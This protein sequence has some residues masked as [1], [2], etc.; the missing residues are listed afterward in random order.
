MDELRTLPHNLE[1]EQSVLGALLIGAPHYIDEVAEIVAPADFY[2]P[3][4]QV[5]YDAILRLHRAG[6]P[7]DAVT[8]LAE[9]D[10]AKDTGRMGG[11]PYLHT[12]TAAVPTAASA[13][14][15]ARLVKDCEKMRRLVEVGTRL[16]SYGY[17]GDPAEADAMIARAHE[18]LIDQ[19]AED[20]GETKTL[21]AAFTARLDRL[22]SRTPTPRVP[23]PYPDLGSLLG[24]GLRPGQFVVIAAR[25][26]IG[27]S[28]MAL[29]IAR[30]ATL[31][32]GMPVYVASKE[33][34]T[35]E[36]VDRIA[37]AEGRIHHEAITTEQLSPDD[38]DRLAKVMETI[39]PVG[40]LMVLDD[41]AGGSIDQ[42]RAGLRKMAQQGSPAR[43]L[44]LDYIQLMEG[45]A[46][47]ENRQQEVA[48]LS[49]AL[50]LLAKEFKI[51]VVALSQLNRNPEARHDKRPQL[52]DLRDS[53]AIEQDADIVILLHREDFYDPQ[54]G[55]PGEVEVM[56][57][58]HRGGRTGT[59]RL[60][61]QLHYS[62][63]VSMTS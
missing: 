39:S 48:G 40:D 58:K 18:N 7:V 62:R 38:W 33:M 31:R 53:G 1:A 19:A 36:L 29:D 46:R 55:R 42:L 28:T 26:S 11:G 44:V 43:L 4:H 60:A 41:R 10:R 5:I 2:R 3:A 14:Y 23:V 34:A 17:N 22:E 13:G 32:H 54:A 37:A 27:K 12:L 20:Q 59:I 8:V 57:V 21:L 61:N 9:L 35:D 25:P 52:A 56:V 15:Y 47:S 51:P 16:A 50:K 49:R 63:F 30:E 24:G 6:Q 45:M